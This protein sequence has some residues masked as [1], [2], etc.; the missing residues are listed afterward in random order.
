MLAEPFLDQ[1]TI[2]NEVSKQIV[3]LYCSLGFSPG[4][5]ILGNGIPNNNL[6]PRIP[7]FSKKFY[8]DK[9]FTTN[10]KTITI[11]Q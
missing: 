8:F 3:G 7:E 11:V 6:F 5:N 9:E 10:F 2:L 4:K 1:C